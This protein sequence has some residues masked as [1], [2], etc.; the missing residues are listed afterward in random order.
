MVTAVLSDSR[1]A[2]LVCVGALLLLNAIG[3]GISIAAELPTEF[4]TR[5]DPD[6]VLEDSVTKGT[7]IAAPLTAMAALIVG[8]LL[9]WFGGRWLGTLGLVITAVLAVLATIGTLGEPLHPEA[10]D[11][12]VAFLVAWKVIVVFLALS[13]VALCLVRGWQIWRPAD[14]P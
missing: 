11:P 8:A 9:F 10:S 12:P 14:A 6:K 13:L 7:L 4:D 5:G 1:K 2:L 3:L